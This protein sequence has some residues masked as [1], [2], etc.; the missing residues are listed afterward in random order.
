MGRP[1]STPDLARISTPTLVIVGEEDVVTPPSDSEL[2]QRSIARSRLV[3]LPRTGHLSSVEAPDDFSRALERLSFLEFVTP[4][5]DAFPG[6]SHCLVRFCWR[7]SLHRLKRR[8]PRRPIRCTGRSIRFSTQRPRRPGLLPRAQ[9]SARPARSLRRVAERDAR[10]LRGWPREAQMAFWVNAY[11]AFVLQTRHRPLP[12][13]RAQR[14]L[15]RASIRQIPGAFEQ[16]PA[17]RRRAERDARRDRED[18]PAGVQGAA[19]LPRARPRRGRQRPP[20]QR[21]LHRRIG[22]S[23]NS[24][25]CRRSSSP[26]AHAQSTARRAGLRYADSQLARG[27][28]RRGLRQ[29]RDRPVRAALARSSARS[30]RSSRPHLLPLENEF[31]EKNQFKMTFHPFDWRLNDLTGGAPSDGCGA[32]PRRWAQSGS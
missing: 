31:I 10:D 17:S 23:S 3:L 2:L 16:R 14:R 20:A 32:G 27:R 21:G 1:D 5:S 7:F 30:S 9:G 28:V 26:T 29:G 13:S 12:D 24:P 15:S 25:R 11:N 22:S 19:A 8:P 4:S 18:D 6:S